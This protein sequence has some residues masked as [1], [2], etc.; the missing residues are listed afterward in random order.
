MGVFGQTSFKLVDKIPFDNSIFTQGL[1]FHNGDLYISGGK[2]GASALYKY[3]LKTRDLSRIHTFPSDVFAEGIA[4]LKN[5]IHCLSWKSQKAFVYS[6]EK[7]RVTSTYSYRGEGW[8]LSHKDSTFVMSNGSER[9]QFY[10]IKKPGDIV[11]EITV[12]DATQSYSKLNELEWIGDRILSNVWYSDE[13]LIIDAVS[14]EVKEKFYP[15]EQISSKELEGCG[16]LNGIAY[17]EEHKL[18]YVTGKNWGFVYVFEV[19]FR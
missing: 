6:L 15:K 11:S 16:V 5:E 12:D 4:I 17:D 3:D 13:I 14:G 8:G 2:Y 9:L 1:V 10:N 7:S 18:L 19:S